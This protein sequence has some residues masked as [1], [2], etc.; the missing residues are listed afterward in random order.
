[1]VKRYIAIASRPTQRPAMRDVTDIPDAW[2]IYPNYVSYEDYAALQTVAQHYKG[3]VS[4][5]EARC[6]ELEASLK[7]CLSFKSDEFCRSLTAATEQAKE[8]ALKS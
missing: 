1:M 5:L 7:Q 4:A 3:E 2:E 8:K 6:G